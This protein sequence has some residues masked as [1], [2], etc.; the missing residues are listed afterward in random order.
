MS[1]SGSPIDPERERR[2]LAN[3]ENLR[4]HYNLQRKQSSTAA[5]S[6]ASDIGPSAARVSR[7]EGVGQ[8]PGPAGQG[9]RPSENGR[10]RA[11][12][13]D[14]KTKGKGKADQGEGLDLGK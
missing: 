14:E 12:A 1:T 6:P 10:G 2:R 13:A 3:R 4:A 8:R 9:S 11:V 5:S 7:G